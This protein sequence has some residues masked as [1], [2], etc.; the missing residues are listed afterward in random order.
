[1][2]SSY[3]PHKKSVLTIEKFVDG[4]IRVTQRGFWELWWGIFHI[5]KMRP[6]VKWYLILKV[7]ISLLNLIVMSELRYYEPF[8]N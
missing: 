1:M 6:S 8:P 2:K 7:G 5:Q 4:Q 3:L